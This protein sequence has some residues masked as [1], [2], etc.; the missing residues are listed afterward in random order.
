MS[1]P[2]RVHDSRPVSAAQRVIAAAWAS[3]AESA[4]AVAQALEDAGLLRPA[5]AVAEAAQQRKQLETAGTMGAR[6]YRHTDEL[7]AEILRLQARLAVLEQRGEP[8][9]SGP[10][11]I[12]VRRFSTGVVLDV[13]H[14]LE[15]VVTA[16]ADD[17][18]LMGLLLDI[19]EDRAMVREYD[20][21][22]PERCRVERLCAALG[23]ELVVDGDAVDGLIGRLR[24]AVPGAPVARERAEGGEGR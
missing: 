10:K 15:S 9:V 17:D 6:A 13:E 11:R 23:Y 14:Y 21:Y 7:V 18:E 19:A 12:Y 8:A 5:D 20:G 22:A 4:A 24:E 2:V 3:G 16:L 1:A